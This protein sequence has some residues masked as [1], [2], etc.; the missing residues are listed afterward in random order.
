MSNIVPVCGWIMVWRNKQIEEVL[1]LEAFGEGGSCYCL[2]PVLFVCFL[3]CFWAFKTNI[4]VKHSLDFIMKK[5]CFIWIQCS[6]WS[7]WKRSALK[8]VTWKYL[9]ETENY[10]KLNLNILMEFNNLGGWSC[11]R[12]WCWWLTS[13]EEVTIRG[14]W[15]LLTSHSS[16]LWRWLRYG[17]V[18]PKQRFLSLIKFHQ[19]TLWNFHSIVHSIRKPS[20]FIIH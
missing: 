4:S 7:S 6:C 9:N 5:K 11:C 17:N 14:K 3:F 13:W 8:P 18:C 12:C 15:R 19:A 2:S 20:R 10:L 16:W 1:P